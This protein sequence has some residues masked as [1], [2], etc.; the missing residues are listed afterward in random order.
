M[1][2]GRVWFLA[3]E[4]VPAWAIFA[5]FGVMMVFHFVWALFF[6]PETKGRRLEEIAA[7]VLQLP[8]Q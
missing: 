8:H 5:F 2:R 3:A 6:V 1:T 4:A 7:G